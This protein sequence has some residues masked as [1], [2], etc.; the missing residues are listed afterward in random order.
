MT[1]VTI[2]ASAVDAEIINMMI[3]CSF[4][5]CSTE[6]PPRMAPVIIPGIEMMPMTLH[7]HTTGS[8]T[9]TDKRHV[10]AGWEC[11]G[12]HLIDGRGER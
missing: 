2:A 3:I 8:S 11:D 4:A 9:W 6:E 10:E 1:V 7:I 5:A 12:P